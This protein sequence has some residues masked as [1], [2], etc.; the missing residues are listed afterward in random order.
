M[1]TSA[2]RQ[3]GIWAMSAFD[4]VDGSSTGTRVPYT[5]V[6]LKLP[7]FGSA[8]K[9]VRTEGV[10]QL[11]FQFPVLGGAGAPYAGFDRWANFAFVFPSF[12]SG[13]TTPSGWQLSRNDSSNVLRQLFQG[14]SLF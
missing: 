14:E 2:I 4:A 9:F 8:K 3:A 1:F 10:S 6:L 13:A 5:W 7:R 12:R 11:R